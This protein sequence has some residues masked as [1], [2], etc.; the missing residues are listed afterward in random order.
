MAFKQISSAF[1]SEQ[2]VGTLYASLL[3]AIGGE[4]LPTPSDGIDFW[5]ERKWRIQLEKGEITPKQ[6]WRRI[7]IKYYGLD[8]LWW[9]IV[10]GT[11]ILVKG[12]ARRKMIVVGG[13]VGAGAAIGVISKNI[14]KDIK[15][16]ENYKLIP[17][18]EYEKLQAIKNKITT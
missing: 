9:T 6:Y 11:A 1:K 10:F 14:Q 15:Y 13:V 2:A 3:G 5:L 7:E 16:F 17:K 8:A 18:D 4:I 12:D